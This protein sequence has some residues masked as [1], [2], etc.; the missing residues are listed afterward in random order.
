VFATAFKEAL[1]SFF[2]WRHRKGDQR[3]EEARRLLVQGREHAVGGRTK[4]ARKLMQRAHRKASG[5]T[6]MSLEMARVELADGKPESAERRLK[7]LLENEPRNAETLALLLELYRGRG[8]IEGQMATLS[9]WLEADPNHLPTLRALRDLYRNTGNWSEAVRIQ[10]RVWTRAEGRSVRSEERRCLTEL[11]YQA[12]RRLQPENARPLLE[13]L[14]QDNEGFAPAHMALGETLLAAGEA[15]AAVQA[16]I[17]GYHAT[18]QIGLLLRAEEVQ[19]DEGR[20][21]DM[22]KLYRRLARKDGLALLLRV[23]LLLSLERSD[24]AL[25]ILER[26]T[27]D[28]K[29]RL[30]T[31]LLGET[32]YRLRSYDGAARAFRES[33]FGAN[34]RLPVPFTCRNCGKQTGR[35]GPTCPFCEACDILDL[36]LDAVPPV[37]PAVS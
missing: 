21:E 14:I 27:S 36:D 23:R 2:F 6:L 3:Q 11:R 7:K 5:E 10:E 17:R 18:G 28:G 29:G 33:V 15:E 19:T 8:D 20:T 22:L 16:W 37:A 30:G 12:A 4:M 35:W 31:L 13:R 25:N 9:R 32:L 26:E 34:G 24:E 1:R